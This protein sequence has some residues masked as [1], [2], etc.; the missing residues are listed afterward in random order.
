MN[1]LEHNKH[2]RWTRGVKESVFCKCGQRLYYGRLPTSSKD[3]EFTA[4][5][6]DE[7]IGEKAERLIKELTSGLTKSGKPRKER[8]KPK[9]KYGKTFG[10]KK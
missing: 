6:L 7:M 4:L 9:P 2:G 3:Q 8:A 1:Y 10:V 5:Y